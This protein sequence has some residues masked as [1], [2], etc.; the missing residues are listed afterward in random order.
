MKVAEEGICFVLCIFGGSRS[1]S[2]SS[3]PSA[4]HSASEPESKEGRPL[5]LSVYVAEG[6]AA[7]RC[8]KVICD[9][10]LLPACRMSS[11]ARCGGNSLCVS[12]W[13]WSFAS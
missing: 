8:A 12:C 11:G 13:V 6:R 5:G 3:C 9:G 4:G 7:R 1:A 10:K 2:A